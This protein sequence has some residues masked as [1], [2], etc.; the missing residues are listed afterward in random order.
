MPFDSQKSNFGV[1][2]AIQVL[3]K[4][5]QEL[6]VFTSHKKLTYKRKSVDGT[7]HLYKNGKKVKRKEE[8][9]KFGP[10]NDKVVI[11]RHTPPPRG[12]Q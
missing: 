7:F 12:L 3:K 6:Q 11:I 2:Y 4:F 10:L 9:L 1:K 8:K 5:G